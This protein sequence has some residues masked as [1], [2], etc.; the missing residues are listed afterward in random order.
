MNHSKLMILLL[1]AG[2]CG[3]IGPVV[4]EPMPD[5]PETVEYDTV[6]IEYGDDDLLT[7][8]SA[9]GA[10]V[11]D[12]SPIAQITMAFVRGTNGV[13]RGQMQLIDALT[14]T[15][16]TDWGD[17]YWIWDNSEDRRSSELFSHFE[18]R[19]LSDDDFEYAWQLG[20]TSDA[21][22][23]VFSGEFR[24]RA[25]FEGRQR[26]LGIL[27]FNFT[28]LHQVDPDSDPS[29]GRVA[30]AFRAI[31]GVRQVRVASFDVVDEENPEP[32]SATYGY[33]QFRDGAGRFR[34]A[35]Q[36]DFLKDGAPLEELSIDTAWT[37]DAEGRALASLTGGSLLVN[38]VLLHECWDE[39]GRTV[40]ADATPDIAFPYEDGVVDSCNARLLEFELSPPP[41]VIPQTDPEIPAPHPDEFEEIIVDGD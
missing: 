35:A 19:R 14:R 22:V 6:R 33:E 34:F 12:P 26:G 39:A 2:G 18:I 36:T 16:P 5:I 24:P 13:I 15:R 10:L 41:L 17:D 28:N 4:T 38:E 40:F 30:I 11:G 1:V 31:G 7:A 21:M 8:S 23:E 29:Q 20:D 37:R 25:R 3:P 9:L 32:R 27:R